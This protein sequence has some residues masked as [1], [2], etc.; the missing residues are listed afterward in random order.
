[1]D[2]LDLHTGRIEKH[3]LQLIK[4]NKTNCIVSI[5][6]STSFVFGQNATKILGIEIPTKLL[7]D[8]FGVL[9]CW[10]I[11][12]FFYFLIFRS[13]AHIG[14][15]TSSLKN[16][17]DLYTSDQNKLSK[18]MQKQKDEYIKFYYKEIK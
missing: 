6:I 17:F 5:V 1:M 7:G 8:N 2:D 9:I 15:A 11:V 18:K 16:T 10:A 4:L 3:H 12:M 14:Y 13:L